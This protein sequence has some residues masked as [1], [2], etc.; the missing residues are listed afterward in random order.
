MFLVM[1]SIVCSCGIVVV[2]QPE[3]LQRSAVMQ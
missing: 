3:F 1:S 2:V